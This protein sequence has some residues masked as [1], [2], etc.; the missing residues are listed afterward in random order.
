MNKA[1]LSAKMRDLGGMLYAAKASL[2]DAFLG[3]RVTGHFL[4]LLLCFVNLT[5]S[6]VSGYERHSACIVISSFS[7]RTVSHHPH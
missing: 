4:Q 2:G 1:Q 6:E 5:I 3:A 7:S